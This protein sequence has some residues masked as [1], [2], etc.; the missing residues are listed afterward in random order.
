MVGSIELQMI[1]KILTS[2]DESVVNSLCQYDESYYSVLREH[3]EF[4][5]NHRQIYGDIPDV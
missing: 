1:S 2:D 4:I 3:I 5:L